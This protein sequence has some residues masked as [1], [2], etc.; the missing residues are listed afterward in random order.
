MAIFFLEA[1]QRK[2]HRKIRECKPSFSR[3]DNRKTVE[4]FGIAYDV[5][6]EQDNRKPVKKSEMKAIFIRKKTI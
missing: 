2:N 5:F 4:R 1:R 6:L 3:Q